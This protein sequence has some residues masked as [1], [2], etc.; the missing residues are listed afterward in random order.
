LYGDVFSRSPAVYAADPCDR[1][2]LEGYAEKVLEAMI[3]HDPG[4]LMPAK[5]VRYTEND[6]ELILGDGLSFGL[7]GAFK[8][9]PGTFNRH[10]LQGFVTMR[11]GWS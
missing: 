1:K 3:E 8:E 7:I 9:A 5:D 11:C 6:V 10:F 2:F 4:R